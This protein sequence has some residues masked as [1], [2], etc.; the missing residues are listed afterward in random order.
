MIDP[1]QRV[2]QTAARLSRLELIKFYLLFSVYPL[3]RLKYKVIL[4]SL[5]FNW[6]LRFYGGVVVDL[7][8]YGRAT[9]EL[10]RAMVDLW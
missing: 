6:V 7:C 1:P 3:H 5:S 2:Q 10:C 4:L 9:V 8:I